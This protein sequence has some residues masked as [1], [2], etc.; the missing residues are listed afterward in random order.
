[1]NS[2]KPLRV[3]RN[4]FYADLGRRA[5]TLFELCDAILTA[6]RVPSPPHLSLVSVHRRGWGSLYAALRKGGVNEEGVR[7]LLASC[8]LG[9]PRANHTPV[10]AVDLVW[11]RC[12]AEASPGRGF[13]YHPSRHSAGQP[14]VAG[15]AYQ[16]VAQLGF[17]RDSWVA[18]VDGRRARPRCVAA[19]SY[20]SGE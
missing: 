8:P 17:C 18:P 20:P 19:E 11:P 1:V 15:W 9:C 10:Y 3:F 14:I 4:R 6:G 12:D 2:M 7:K 13:Y 16:L 5:D